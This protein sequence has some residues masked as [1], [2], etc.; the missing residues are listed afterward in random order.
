MNLIRRR[1]SNVLVVHHPDTKFGPI[2]PE[3][4]REVMVRHNGGDGQRP[5][6]ETLL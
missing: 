5:L 3:V 2:D 1:G 4:C 6:P